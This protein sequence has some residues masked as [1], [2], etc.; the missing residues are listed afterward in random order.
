MRNFQVNDGGSSWALGCSAGSISNGR[1]QHIA[2]TWDGTTWKI[3]QNGELAGSGAWAG[4]LVSSS[5][6]VTIGSNSE[7]NTT[8]FGGI[9]DELRV[10]NVARSQ[11]EIQ[12]AMS[13]ELTG[14]EAGLV[15]Y[16]SMNEGAGQT[17][18]DAAGAANDGRRGTTDAVD[19]ADPGWLMASGLGHF[20]PGWV[21]YGAP[22]AGNAD[23]R[24]ASVGG[25]VM[26][27]ES[28]HGDE[29]F[30][31]LSQIQAGQSVLPNLRL[32]HG[33]TLDPVIEVR[34]A[35]GTVAD[36]IGVAPNPVAATARA[37]ITTS[38]IYYA[39]VRAWEGEG[40]R[41]EYLLDVA[42]KDTA[43]LDFADLSVHHID[44]LVPAAPGQTMAVDWTVGNYGAAATGAGSWYDRVVLSQDDIAG[45]AV[46]AILVGAGQLRVGMVSSTGQLLAPGLREIA[47]LQFRVESSAGSAALRRLEDD[48]LKPVLRTL[49]QVVTLDIEPVDPHAGGYTWTAVDGGV[50]LAAPEA[51]HKA[52]YPRDAGASRLPDRLF[53]NLEAELSPLENV[54]TDLAGDIASEWF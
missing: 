13:H 5:S 50:A 6:P 24:Q 14:S 28:G 17:V 36:V 27:G 16:W 8:K 9:I 46:S 42:I 1:W 35:P 49:D 4:P 52:T 10:W 47:R 23:Y 51:W 38:G 54:L 21:M 53:V 40:P 31:N 37:D 29:D 3:Y 33:S 25:T 48:R 2:G 43:E 11:A 39:V 30:F 7:F 19:A 22:L 15:S 44:L 18:A 26:A 32:P 12:E 34:K 20:S 45:W 41:A